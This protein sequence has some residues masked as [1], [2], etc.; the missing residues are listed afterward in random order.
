[1]THIKPSRIVASIDSSNSY[2]LN[3][4]YKNEKKNAKDY[5]LIMGHPKSFT[6]Y[7]LMYLDKFLNQLSKNDKNITI[8][9][10]ARKKEL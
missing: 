5:M 7:S 1:M 8:S 6:P 9:F 10:F 3:Y 4:I 2:F